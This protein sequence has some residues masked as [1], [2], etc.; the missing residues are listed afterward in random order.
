[1]QWLECLLAAALAEQEGL[2][3]VVTKPGR[4]IKHLRAAVEA[5]VIFVIIP[6]CFGLWG[7]LLV[8]AISATGLVYTINQFDQRVLKED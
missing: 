7:L 1:M 5:Y 4:K 2:F 6:S 8:F 3:T